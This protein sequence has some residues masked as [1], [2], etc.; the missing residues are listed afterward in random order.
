VRV[1]VGIFVG[2]QARRL[3]GI[4]KGLLAT[5]DGRSIAARMIDVISEAVP[6]ALVYL[7]GNA[8]AYAGLGLP[9]LE[10]TPPGIG[11]LGGLVALLRRADQTNHEGAL[12]LSCDLPAIDA[13]F[14]RRL[15]N[16]SPGA[17]A[18]A[19]KVDSERWSPL[20]ARYLTGALPALEALIAA[21]EHSLQRVFERLGERAVE[22][23]TT[24]EELERLV[25]WD[26]PEDVN[27]R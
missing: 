16:E 9:A 24:R 2:G 15:S 17:L 6:G 22:M 3:G 8:S 19:P 7:V 11:P 21:G 10:D 5:P 18:L 14:L 25:D 23:V 20:S 12:A 4:A 27:R 26:T 13:E 1:V